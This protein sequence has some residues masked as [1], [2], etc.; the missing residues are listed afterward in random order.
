MNDTLTPTPG[1]LHPADADTL[2]FQPQSHDQPEQ[3]LGGD[4]I[5]FS[6][7]ELPPEPFSEGW[8]PTYEEPAGEYIPPQP[9]SPPPK[10]RIQQLKQKLMEGPERRYYTLLE[11]GFTGLQIRI[12]LSI[13]LSAL[14]VAGVALYQLDMVR[15]DRMR[16]LIF[17]QCFAMLLSALLAS[18]H[19]M[20]G[21]LVLFRGKFTMDSLL[22]AT[23]AACI[24]DGVFCLREIRLPF[25]ALFC[26]EVTMALWSAY[27]KKYVE[28]AQ[29]DTL[30]KATRL[31]RV[32][33]APDC[34]DGLPGFFAAPGEV[35]DFMDNYR[36]DPAPL[37][38]LNQYALASVLLSAAIGGLGWARLGLSQ[39]VQTLAG[40][41]LAA[42]P[43]TL[44]I[45]VSRSSA[46]LQGKLHQLGSV[47][48]GWTGVQTSAGAAVVPLGD[49]DLLP[50]GSVKINGMKFYTRRDPDLIIAMAAAVAVQSRTCFE[51]LFNQLLESRNAPRYAASHRQV[52]DDGGVSAQVCGLPVLMGTLT[53]LKNSGIPIPEEAG[54]TQAVYVAIDGELSGIF[55]VSFGKLRRVRSG[56]GTL[57]SHRHLK[58]LLTSD[59]FLLDAAFVKSKF[60]V[61]SRRFQIP[62][63]Q[64]RAALAAWQPDPESGELCALTTQEGLSA[65]AYAITGGRT[66]ES[67]TWFGSLLH[68]TGGSVGMLLVLVLMLVDALGLVNPGYLLLF[69]LLWAIPGFLLTEWTRYL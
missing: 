59:N 1:E 4:T 39:G 49:H 8:E 32:C 60:R 48:C 44:F 57:C 47:L 63:A 36:D 15:P 43:L 52:Y 20:E 64:S 40:C 41:L 53:F 68:V 30:R 19:L 66:L 14:T 6:P 10:S 24:A 62:D 2:T 37:R 42:T 35:E 46:V 12:F 67:A 26:L 27:Q 7:V 65:A 3:A 21:I 11:E 22:S 13:L 18:S 5:R 58:V 23:F 61:S 31:N 51:G 50:A 16:L 45:T 28:L 33:K 54:V 69:Q 55:A 34:Y 9:A 56:L 38:R 17:S 25:C 29:M